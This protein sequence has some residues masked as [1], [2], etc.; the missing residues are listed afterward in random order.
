MV[1][2]AERPAAVRRHRDPVHI[3]ARQSAGREHG[4]VEQ[5]AVDELLHG[6]HGLCPRMGHG[7]EL[8][9]AADPDIAGAVGHGRVH[10]HH[11]GLDRRQ[12]HD[13]IVRAERIV[14]H[15]P[16]RPVNENVGADDAAQRHERHAL[17]RRLERCMQSRAGRVLHADGRRRD[18]GDKPRRR[19]ELA[20]AHGGCLEHADAAGAD[21]EIG[22]QARGRQRHQMEV[23]HAA[24]DQGA[25][26]FHRHA[27]DLA[28][29]R[30]HDA[31]ADR[32]ER[33]LDGLGDDRHG[34][35]FVQANVGW[36]EPLRN[37]SCGRRWVSLRSTHPTDPRFKTSEK[38]CKRIEKGPK[39]HVGSRPRAARALHRPGD[40]AIRRRS[41]RRRARPLQ[42]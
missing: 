24:A 25:C 14:D 1:G 41:S 36:V 18:R 29:H 15:P 39:Q 9:L 26:R 17:L 7:G 28:R 4:I 30:Q 40:A 11:V 20:E 3:E 38:P 21:Q 8:A 10:Q 23:L 27:G 19:S 6:D 5:I 35:S 32:R 34:C 16:V 2:Q 42:R 37:P 12:Q 33:L 22:L 31:V 13:R